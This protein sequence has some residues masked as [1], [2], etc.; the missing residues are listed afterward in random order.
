[1][2][3]KGVYGEIFLISQQEVWDGTINFS[4]SSSEHKFKWFILSQKYLR[5]IPTLF[6][7]VE[8]EDVTTLGSD[9]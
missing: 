2:E 3:M 9:Q 4:R 5:L 7:V 6:E 1:M 8:V